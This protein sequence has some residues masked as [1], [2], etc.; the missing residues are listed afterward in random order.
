M[1]PLGAGFRILVLKLVALG[2]GSTRDVFF[3]R[4]Y[5]GLG[6]RLFWVHV[7]RGSRI[8]YFCHMYTLRVF[9]DRKRP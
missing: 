6:L 8:S 2:K 5:E 3:R 7:P 1:H 4:C 9:Y